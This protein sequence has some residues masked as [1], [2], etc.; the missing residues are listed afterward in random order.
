MKKI[1]LFFL[2]LSSLGILVAQPDREDSE[3][4]KEPVL[5]VED[6]ALEGM[7]VAIFAGGCFW[8]VEAPYE[9]ILGVAKAV[10]GYSGGHVENPTYQQVSSGSTGHL[11]VVKVYFDPRIISYETLVDIF[12]RQFDPT[13]DGGSFVDRG[14]QYTSAIFYTTADQR[15]I[16]EASKAALDASGTYKDPVITPI[17]PAEVFYPA[18]EY[19]Q[20][21]YKK[22]FLHY[23]YY[24]NGSGRDNFLDSVWQDDRIPEG[25]ALKMDKFTDFDKDSRVDE[26][27]DL[28]CEVTQDGGTEQAFNNAY[29][30]N[31][32]EGIYVDV[33]SGEPLFSSVEKYQSGSGW[34]SFFQPLE[35]DNITYHKDTTLGAV[36]TEVRSKFGDSHLGHVFEDGPNP[37]GLRYCVNSAS[38]R[39]IS[40]DQMETEGYGDY[41]KIFE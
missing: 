8:C 21:Y 15:E 39:F 36:R 38:L 1:I 20:D 7:D 32:T 35:P 18:E 40:R 33:V 11:E 3:M 5:T 10:S 16:A 14:S 2:I 4:G 31:K 23:Q 22:E 28:Q 9:K 27:T 13:D 25:V 34:P 12:W 26:L 24:R 41:L 19:H 29:W 6:I 37:S 17:R 30:D